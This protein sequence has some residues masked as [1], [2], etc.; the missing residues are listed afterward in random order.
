MRLVQRIARFV[1][2]DLERFLA[3]TR[4]G[5]L[6]RLVVD[7][8]QV[9]NFGNLPV[10]LRVGAGHTLARL[11]VLDVAAAVP[12]QLADVE[13]VVENTG[14]AL[15]LATDRGV[16]PGASVRAGHARCV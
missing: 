1:A 3:L 14:A 10:L 8:A 16:D 5:A 9:R 13:R 4:L 11:R 6:P 15:R 2:A 7:N 12:A